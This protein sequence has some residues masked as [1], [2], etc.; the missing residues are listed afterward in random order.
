MIARNGDAEV[1]DCTVCGWAHLNPIPGEA[2][3]ALM[4]ERHY[5]Q[6]HYPGWLQKD[7]SE[8]AYWDLEHADKLADWSML[9]ERDRGTVVDVGCSGGLLLE[10]AAA[11]G[12][13]GIGIE[14]SSEAVEEAASHAV[15]VRAG[16]YQEVVLEPETIDVVH[17][18]LVGEHMTDPR[19]YVAWAAR[20]LRPGGIVCI[21]VPNDFSPLQLAARDALGKHDWWVA[22]PYHINYF[23]F[24]SLERLLA[25][26]GF[27]PVKRDATYP[28][29]SF[30][31][32]GEDYVGNAELG[33]SVHRRRMTLET[34]LE[35][36]GM[37][38]CF[39]ADL[40]KRGLGREAIVHATKR[41]GV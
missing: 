36:L 32:M 18:K 3:L 15:D 12:W 31:L 4:Y 6:E 14:P 25:G 38:R 13:T 27:D 19:G 26:C 23:N 7:R 16:T 28:V 35:R 1:I 17:C 10:Y 33:S 9:L 22:A 20:S 29:E 5:Y 34:E 11:R 39:H 8:Q 24:D 37:R 21:H 40:A 41:A 2:E 30:L